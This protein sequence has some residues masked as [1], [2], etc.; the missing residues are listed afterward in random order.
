MRADIHRPSK[1]C[2]GR[3]ARSPWPSLVLAAVCSPLLAMPACAADLTSGQ[4]ADMA[5]IAALAQPAAVNAQDRAAMAA[6][7][8]FARRLLARFGLDAQHGDRHGLPG[9]RWSLGVATDGAVRWQAGAYAD[10][11][12]RTWLSAG[13][14]WPLAHTVTA[15]LTWALPLKA[16][17][18]PR[19]TLGLVL[20]F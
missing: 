19:W 6:S 15:N 11:R 9:T 7:R 20:A 14:S 4:Q 8:E 12:S 10:Q 13:M 16:S 17:R 1:V 2:Q 18:Q 5:D 3:A